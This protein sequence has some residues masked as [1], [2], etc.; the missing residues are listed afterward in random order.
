MVNLSSG[1]DA[2]LIIISHLYFLS[3]FSMLHLFLPSLFSENTG[4]NF[5]FHVILIIDYITQQAVNP[6]NSADLVWERAID[7]IHCPG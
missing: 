4:K 6:S 5:L 7:S 3:L 2:I 1:N